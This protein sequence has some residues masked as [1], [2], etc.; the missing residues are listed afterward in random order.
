MINKA[1][2][3]PAYLKSSSLNLVILVEIKFSVHTNH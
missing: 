1:N 2:F 3:S